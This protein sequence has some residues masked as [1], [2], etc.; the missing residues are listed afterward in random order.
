M[1]ARLVSYDNGEIVLAFPLE[2]PQL[3]IG[4]EADND[5]QLP[6][7]KVSKHHAALSWT[8]DRWCIEDLKSTNGIFVNS[9]KV[10]VVELKHGDRVKIGPYELCFETKAPSDQW[11]PSYLMDLS[12]KIHERTLVQTKLPDGLK[13]P[14]DK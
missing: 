5:I 6:H 4:R 14:Q 11:V 3:A 12:P 8:K 7:E 2:G 9:E 1:N 10:H 13:C